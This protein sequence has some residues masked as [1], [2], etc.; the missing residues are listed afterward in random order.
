MSSNGM[1]LSFCDTDRRWWVH[2]LSR[3]ARGS[4]S[5]GD[6]EFS[7]FLT[8]DVCLQAGDCI[9]NTWDLLSVLLFLVDMW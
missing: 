3:S 9:G 6:K 1:A 4:L 7:Y 2:A 8:S 5:C